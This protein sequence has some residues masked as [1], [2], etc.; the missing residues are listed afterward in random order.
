[1]LNPKL[2][3]LCQRLPDGKNHA[4]LSHQKCHS[5]IRKSLFILA[6]SEKIL[7]YSVRMFKNDQKPMSL[8]TQTLPQEKAAFWALFWSTHS[9]GLL[10]QQCIDKW[11]RLTVELVVSRL[12]TFKIQ[13]LKKICQTPKFP[14]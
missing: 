2:D 12:C 9:S 6:A 4:S 5:P 7:Q 13:H 11:Q 14:C 1:M 3:C 10:D 8:K